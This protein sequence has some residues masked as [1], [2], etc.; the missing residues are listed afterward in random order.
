MH[1]AKLAANQQRVSLGYASHVHA[2]SA[3][4]SRPFR[5][6]GHP[7]RGSPVPAPDSCNATTALSFDDLI[8]AQHEFGGNFLTD[9]FRGPEIDDQLE[10]GRLLD[11][12]IG[13]LRAP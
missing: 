12:Q 2:G 6:H 4:P 5:E 10:F 7:C 1:H 3:Y 11:R 9:R 8:G 13:G